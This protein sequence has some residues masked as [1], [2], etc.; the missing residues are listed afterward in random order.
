[1][2]ARSEASFWETLFKHDIKASTT[3]KLLIEGLYGDFVM[4]G[5]DL[6]QSLTDPSK[7]RFNPSIEIL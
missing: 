4:H 7:V 3:T 6:Y 5:I 1:M 2:S